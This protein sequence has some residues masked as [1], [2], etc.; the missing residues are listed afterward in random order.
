[1]KTYSVTLILLWAWICPLFPQ[2]HTVQE[3]NTICIGTRHTVYSKIL[4]EER[5]YWLHVPEALSESE[6]RSCPVIYLLDGDSF[7]HT[8]VGITHFFSGSRTSSLPPCI[9][10]GILNTDR[11]RDFTPTSSTA[12]RD[13]SLHP[14]EKPQG[15]GSERFYHFLTE[16]LRPDIN[17]MVENNGSS[18]LIGHSYAGLFT[19]ETLTLH[20]ESFD[21]FIA[22]DPSLWWDQGVFLAQALPRIT[23]KDFSGKQLYV[24]FATKSRPD[25]R[26]TQFTLAD[27]LQQKILPSLRQKELHTVYRN[28]PDEIHGTI[29]IP[30]LFDGLKNLFR[31]R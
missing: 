9:V 22:I 7:F 27:T 15:G 20:P 19:L 11:T 29:A 26:L 17:R 21:T 25:V 3:E 28:F 13:G 4:N 14:E 1:M 12:R 31:H 23:Q 6:L 16:E 8:L 5:E 10:V 2:Q 30:A 18:M 24:A